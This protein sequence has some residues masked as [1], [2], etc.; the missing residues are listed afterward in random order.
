MKTQN[1]TAKFKKNN[2]LLMKE[3]QTKCPKNEIMIK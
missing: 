2:D 3:K 1:K